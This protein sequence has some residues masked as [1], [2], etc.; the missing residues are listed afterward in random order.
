MR[1][2]CCIILAICVSAAFGCKYDKLVEA[3]AD[4]DVKFGVIGD[5][6]KT[7]SEQ[8]SALQVKAEQIGTAVTT[9]TQQLLGKFEIKTTTIADRIYGGA[10]WVMVACGVIVIIFIAAPIIVFYIMLHHSKEAKEYATLIATAVKNA[11]SETQRIVK[12]EVEKVANGN[13]QK[14]ALFLKK[15]GVFADANV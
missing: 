9:S 7:L 11:P 12:D 13:K 3:K 1:T 14:L 4:T 6:L 8:T 5:S 15:H 2:I 10:G